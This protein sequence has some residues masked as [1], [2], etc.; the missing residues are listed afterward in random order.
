[1][2]WP[3]LHYSLLIDCF[4]Q[5]DE[6][7][8]HGFSQAFVLKPLGQSWFI[9]HDMFRLALHHVAAWPSR[10]RVLMLGFAWSVSCQMLVPDSFPIPSRFNRLECCATL[11]ILILSIFFSLITITPFFHCRLTTTLLNLSCKTLSWSRAETHSSSSTTC[12]GRV[13]QKNII[14]NTEH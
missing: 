12:S 11:L 3:S 9:A 2:F 8:P 6:D 10:A 13:D 5:T 7:P 1:M 14:P 4:C